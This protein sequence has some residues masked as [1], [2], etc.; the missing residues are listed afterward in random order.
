MKA[1]SSMGFKFI[2]R[3]GSKLEVQ[4]RDRIEEYHLIAT[5]PFSSTRKR[6]SVVVRHVSTGKMK[7]FIK[8]AD[9][10]VLPVTKSG[11]KDRVNIMTA[12]IDRYS[13]EGLRTLCVGVRE[14][15]EEEAE[16]WG[17]GFRKA[18]SALEGREVRIE[19]GVGG[20]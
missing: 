13:G 19:R 20:F 2:K 1:A 8:G 12:S 10:M 17:E 5:L 15:E 14:V 7:L 3:E 4:I 9:E 18:S 6:M 16:V 11:S